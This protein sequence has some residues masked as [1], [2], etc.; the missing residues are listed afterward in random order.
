MFREG[1][2]CGR[3]RRHAASISLFN[4]LNNVCLIVDRGFSA[5]WIDSKVLKKTVNVVMMAC[6][7]KNEKSEK[8]EVYNCI[9]AI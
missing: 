5:E 2:E 9:N 3:L 1:G 7:R 6:V 8:K 4:Q